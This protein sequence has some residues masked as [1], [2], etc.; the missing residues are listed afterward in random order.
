MAANACDTVP[1][2]VLVLIFSY[3][4]TQVLLRTVALV[5]KKFDDILKSEWY[6][7]ARHSPYVKHF[8]VEF[9]DVRQRQLACAQFDVLT[10]GGSRD[11]KENSFTLRGPTGAVD[12]V[13]LLNPDLHG[14][15]AV[16]AAGARDGNIYLWRRRR[17]E[18][19][20]RSMRSFTGSV[21]SEHMGWVWSLGSD[22]TSTSLLCS[23]GWDNKVLLWDV[24]AG[25]RVEFIGAHK[26]PVLSLLFPESHVLMTGCF[27]K[28]IREFDVRK[29]ISQTSTL[30]GHRGPVL[31]LGST[32]HYVFSASDDK[33]VCVWDRRTLKRLQKVTHSSIITWLHYDHG[34]LTVTEGGKPTGNVNVYSVTGGQLDFLKAF[35]PGHSRPLTCVSHNLAMIATSS[36]DGLVNLHSW[37]LADKPL[38]S[39]NN[40]KGNS[41]SRIHWNG[42]MLAASGGDMTVSLWVPKSAS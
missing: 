34:I 8:P 12:C 32:G 42:S 14:T 22:P 36:Q 29:P 11:P 4:P 30:S 28:Q 35:N 25:Q 21:L 7:K 10:A 5:C 24:A 40:H 17:E 31:C 23:G 6:W 41:I 9:E 13:L 20:G 38:L 15:N 2:E 3:I 33:T 1:T 19:P 16:I 18:T 37:N 26:F 27:D 39:L